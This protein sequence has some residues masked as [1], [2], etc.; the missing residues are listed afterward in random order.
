MIRAKLTIKMFIKLIF[1]IFILIKFKESTKNIFSKS[2]SSFYANIELTNN[3]YIYHVN[4]FPKK[5]ILHLPLINIECINYSNFT[6]NIKSVELTMNIFNMI[7]IQLLW[8]SEEIF[9]K[10]SLVPFRFN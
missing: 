7:N 8:H 4:T 6:L 2:H 3:E 1:L 9:F 10:E 5:I